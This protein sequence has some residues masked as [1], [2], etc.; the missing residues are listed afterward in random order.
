MFDS[1]QKTHECDVFY[2]F[3]RPVI[4]QRPDITR[5]VSGRGRWVKKHVNVKNEG[6][7]QKT[8]HQMLMLNI[9]SGNIQA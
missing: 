7:M 2:H 3:S 1:M 8:N 4:S 9:I 6:I 5:W